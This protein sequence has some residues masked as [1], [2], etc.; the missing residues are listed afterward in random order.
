MCENCIY[1]K[2]I[3]K[4]NIQKKVIEEKILCSYYI[5]ASPK[6]DPQQVQLPP[7]P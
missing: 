1:N 4:C 5:E 3:M 2:M 6:A 7:L